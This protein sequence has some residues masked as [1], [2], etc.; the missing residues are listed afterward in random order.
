ML[1]NTK[2]DNIRYYISGIYVCKY[3]LEKA[4]YLRCQ[5]QN[6]KMKTKKSLRKIKLLVT[7]KKKQAKHH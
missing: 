1:T 2:L 6:I 7:K 3:R 4:Y 5:Q